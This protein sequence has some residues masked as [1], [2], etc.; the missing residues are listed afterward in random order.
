MP[1]LTTARPLHT[2]VRRDTRPFMGM[3]NRLHHQNGLHHEAVGMGLTLV[4]RAL[5]ALGGAG[6]YM[7]FKRHT[8]RAIA[9]VLLGL[10]GIVSLG[11]LAA[12]GW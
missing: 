9:S 7:W 11:L 4:P 1:L 2:H 8:G 6:V 3:L 10:N 12:L 5:L